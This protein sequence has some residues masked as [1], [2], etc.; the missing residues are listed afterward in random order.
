[1][2]AKSIKALYTIQGCHQDLTYHGTPDIFSTNELYSIFANI[3]IHISYAE[4]CFYNIKELNKNFLI[5]SCCIEFSY[6]LPLLVHQ[7]YQGNYQVW[8][9][10]GV[11]TVPLGPQWGAFQVA[12]GVRLRPLRA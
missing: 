12:M 2:N 7:N 5:I 3:D 10:L 11:I 9:S 4:S 6:G 8:Q 1:M